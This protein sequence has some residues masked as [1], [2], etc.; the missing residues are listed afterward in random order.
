M[1]FEKMKFAELVFTLGLSYDATFVPFSKSRHAKPKF[2]LRD[3][4][5]NWIVLLSRNGVALRVDYSAGIAHIPGYKHH[6]R[7]CVDDYNRVVEACEL[8]K[9]HVNGSF[10]H[11][12][13]IPAPNL[14]DVMY[15]LV[16][17]STAIEYANFEEW[18]DN[19][20][21][22]SDSRKDEAIYKQCLDIALKLRLML[23]D[24]KLVELREAAQDY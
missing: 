4:Q 16:S 10:W 8:G 23:G 18:A 1:Q 9:Y 15:S 14:A 11:T 13:E 24:A 6:H 3:L 17:D 19:L 7:L 2:Q 12:R 20:G 22:N 5:L 21:F